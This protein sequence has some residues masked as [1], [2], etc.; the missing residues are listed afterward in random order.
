MATDREIPEKEFE[1]A[2]A[3]VAIPTTN[4][5]LKKPEREQ[6]E[7]ALAQR[8]IEAARQIGKQVYGV[9]YADPP[10]RF[11]PY[12]RDTG[13]DRAADNHYPTMTLDAIKAMRCRQPMIARCS[14]GRRRRCCRRRWT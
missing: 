11:E 9:I 6:R 10:W 13:M 8:T 12:S 3:K 5:L 7:A 4:S 14:S 2:L 1:A